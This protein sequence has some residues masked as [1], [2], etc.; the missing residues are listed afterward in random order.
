MTLTS[1]RTNRSMHQPFQVRNHVAWWNNTDDSMLNTLEHE[2]SDCPIDLTGWPNRATTFH[3]L[4]RPVEK[5]QVTKG[6]DTV[7]LPVPISQLFTKP[8]KP[9]RRPTKFRGSRT[10]TTHSPTDA[11]TPSPNDDLPTGYPS[12][13]PT[14]EKPHYWFGLVWPPT[15]EPTFKSVWPSL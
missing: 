3:F 1:R 13:E 2:P 11:P 9:S 8:L 4:R 10:P 5:L 14:S 12:L 6:G 15:H 7:P